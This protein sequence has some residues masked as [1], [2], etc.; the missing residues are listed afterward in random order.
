MDLNDSD[1]QEDNNPNES[2]NMNTK[3]DHTFNEHAESNIGDDMDGFDFIQKFIAN[4]KL[5]DYLNAAIENYDNQENEQN[6]ENI[7]P[8]SGYVCATNYFYLK[9]LLKK[10]HWVYIFLGLTKMVKIEMNIIQIGIDHH[11]PR[12]NA[13]EIG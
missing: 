10:F 5:N 2:I 4:E 7:D 11:G 1:K 9:D 12:A 3:S 6:K 8:D 13:Q